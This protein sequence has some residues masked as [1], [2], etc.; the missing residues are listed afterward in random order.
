MVLTSVKLCTLTV[1]DKERGVGYLFLF[2][3]PFLEGQRMLHYQAH[4][5]CHP[6]L[7]TR[8]WVSNVDIL[9]TLKLSR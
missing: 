3:S 6:Y 5:G 4:I 2:S 7:V 8:S 1:A 9:W